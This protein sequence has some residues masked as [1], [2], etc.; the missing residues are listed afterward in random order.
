MARKKFK[1]NLYKNIFFIISSALIII[2]LVVFFLFIKPYLIKQKSIRLYNQLLPEAQYVQQELNKSILLSEILAA[3]LKTFY[4]PNTA[5]FLSDEYLQSIASDILKE[6]YYIQAIGFVIQ[7]DLQLSITNEDYINDNGFFIG[8][9]EKNFNNQIEHRILNLEKTGNENIIL[10]VKNS[11]KPILGKP[12]LYTSQGLNTVMQPIAAPIFVGNKFIGS[13]II[14][15][16]MDF[17]DE[18]YK[19]NIYTQKDNKLLLFNKEGTIL[20][21]PLKLNIGKQLET[22]IPGYSVEILK[23]IAR[24]ENLTGKFG[25]FFITGIYINTIQKDQYW[26]ISIFTPYNK[27]I[28]TVYLALAILIIGALVISIIVIIS[29]SLISAPFENIFT[30]MIKSA[31]NLYK[32]EL[33]DN[34]EII[35]SFEETYQITHTL[36]RL[37][38][39]LISTVDL[40]N[41]LAERIYTDRLPVLSPRDRLA[42][43]INNAFEKIIQRWKDRLEMEENKRKSDWINQGIAA[44]YEAVRIQQNSYQLL[45]EQVLDS[46][47]K[48]ANP[49]IAGFFIYDQEKNKLKAV[50]AFAYE[51]KRSFD[52]EIEPGQ[53]YIGNAVLEKK[54]TYIKKL[55]DDYH[56]YLLGL[57]ETKPKSALILPIVMNEEIL[58]AI[59]L[60]FLR[61]LEDYEF[62][63]FDKSTI[64]IA[65]AI[66]SI[67]INLRTEKLL[68]QSRQQAQELEK[69][70]ELL[71]QQIESLKQREEEL[72][73]TQQ[74]TK[75][76][77]QAVNHTLLT[78]EYQTDGTFISAN[79]LFLQKME[80]SLDELEGINVLEIVPEDQQKDLKQIIKRVAK[81]EHISK[82][83]KRQTKYGEVIWLYA[84]YTPFYDLSG[85]IT[86]ILFFAFDI[87]ETYKRIQELEEKVQRLNEEIA[88]LEKALNEL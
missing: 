83:V 43:S 15:L 80:Y 36:E 26:I 51:E 63:Y 34:V 39:R 16:S 45:G 44:M 40:H 38:L 1:N 6:N 12:F 30:S 32:G 29:L 28:S 77:L 79:E 71:Q 42:K 20:F 49:V 25:D 41:K 76:I 62:E 67:Q 53:G 61:E 13:V 4:T 9:W 31:T 17:M 57:G 21:Y 54:M 48:H 7:A 59:E 3:N 73:K 14:F 81:G 82:I 70:K 68:E 52:R 72:R 8:I 84:T 22:I 10:E 47:I 23:T 85:T 55:P 46:F 65:Q 58:G 66:K 60:L 18:A 33:D 24:K 37:R 50:A 78:V 35:S 86:K 69:T 75:G 56:L 64:A 19:L 5:L 87:S 11:K 74:E 88:A 27:F 2:V